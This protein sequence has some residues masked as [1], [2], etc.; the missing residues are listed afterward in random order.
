[1]R[2]ATTTCLLLAL[3]TATLAAEDQWQREVADLRRMMAEVQRTLA[4]AQT[5]ANAIRAAAQKPGVAQ[6]PAAPQPAPP[7]LLLRLLE[8][9]QQIVQRLDRMDDRLAQLDAQQQSAEL[10][11]FGRTTV[12][13]NR[14]RTIEAPPKPAVALGYTPPAPGYIV[15]RSPV[16]AGD[17]AWHRVRLPGYSPSHTSHRYACPWDWRPHMRGWP[18]WPLY[19]PHARPADGASGWSVR[20]HQGGL[21]ARIHW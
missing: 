7:P 17:G 16:D 1:M 13:L 18:T 4:D 12:D 10:A 11:E 19:R 21:S 5:Q 9:Q 15:G 3:A 8:T 6:E 14:H 20:I 2:I